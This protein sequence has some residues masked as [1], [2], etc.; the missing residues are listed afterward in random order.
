MENRI[1]TC[2]HSVRLHVLNPDGMARCLGR[3]FDLTPDQK[4]DLT[5]ERPC[6]CQ[7]WEPQEQADD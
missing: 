4:L 6:D 2:K 1:C 7:K 3:S 5:S